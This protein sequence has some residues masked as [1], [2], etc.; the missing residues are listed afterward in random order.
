MAH[1]PINP[2]ERGLFVSSAI[3]IAYATA[4][5]VWT[6]VIAYNAHTCWHYARKHNAWHTACF[7]CACLMCLSWLCQPL[8]G[9]WMRPCNAHG[10]YGSLPC[11]FSWPF[12]C[13]PT[14]YCLRN[15]RTRNL[16]FLTL[17][18]PALFAFHAHTCL[19]RALCLR[20]ALA[21]PHRNKFLVCSS[22]KPSQA[23]PTPAGQGPWFRIVVRA[24][25]LTWMGSGIT[26]PH[27]AKVLAL[28]PE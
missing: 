22:G 18:L 8:H 11:H 25:A 9:L 4:P 3:G 7:G 2:Y 5:Y 13:G 16:R 10:T 24:K 26:C 23:N 21:G 1:C 27:T 17:P 15:T 14:P 20:N 19:A 6:H 12:G 28:L